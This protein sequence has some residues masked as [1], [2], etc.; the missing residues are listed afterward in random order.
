MIRHVEG[1]YHGYGVFHN[2]RYLFCDCRAV[3]R[4]SLQG[5]GVS[6]SH[7]DFIILFAQD[8]QI[9]KYYNEIFAELFLKK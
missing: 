5:Q 8:F 3:D 2:P 9:L 4:K 6:I 7:V 1:V